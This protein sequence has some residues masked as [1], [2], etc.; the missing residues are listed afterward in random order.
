MHQLEFSMVTSVRKLKCL[1]TSFCLTHFTTST[2]KDGTAFWRFYPRNNL[3]E[4]ELERANP[5]K[6]K[7]SLL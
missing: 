7:D 5:K 1:G 2:E 4:D 6:L 3:T